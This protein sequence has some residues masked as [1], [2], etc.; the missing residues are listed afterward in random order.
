MHTNCKLLIK[1]HLF[2]SIDFNK[3]HCEGPAF[4]SE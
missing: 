2:W 1:E 4:M 3:I